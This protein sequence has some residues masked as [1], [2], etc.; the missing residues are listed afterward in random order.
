MDPIHEPFNPLQLW[1]GSYYMERIH[2]E[3]LQLCARGLMLSILHWQHSITWIILH[4][5]W[6]RAVN[7]WDQ[8][9]HGILGAWYLRVD[10][11]FLQHGRLGF[12]HGE[13]ALLKIQQMIHI[14]ID[15]NR[16][17]FGGGNVSLSKGMDCC[18]WGNMCRCRM[19]S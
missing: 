4:Y 19:S 2:C 5:C 11:S 1:L 3:L 10:C 12:S 13:D 6:I 17:G 7:R 18:V 9:K 16:G 15:G 14:G 8:C